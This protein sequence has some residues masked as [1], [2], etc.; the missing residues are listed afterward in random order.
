[1]IRTTISIVTVVAAIAMISCGSDS[2]IT[3][4]KLQ[5]GDDSLSYAFGVHN[6][7]SL[8][9][10]EGIN[11]DPVAMA[12]GMIEARD[13]SS[14]MDHMEAQTY[15]MEYIQ[16]LDEG[17]MMEQY[18]HV[19]EE[20]ERFLEENKQRDG[21]ITT[22]SGLQYE[23]LREGDGPRPSRESVVRVHYKGEFLSGEQF[24]SSYDRGEPAEFPLSGVIPG[25]T[26]VVQLMPVGSKF[27]VYLPYNL[28]YGTQQA[29]PIDP[30]STLIFEIELLDILD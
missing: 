28:G 20:G 23:I 4:K 3:S 13:G 18:S 25:W 17:A 9:Q 10:E 27:K 2:A 22:E 12:K 6:F 29:G 1:M 19:R 7:H 8:D 5:T 30:F 16:A 14:F 15:M 11:I 24:D 26:E 21:V